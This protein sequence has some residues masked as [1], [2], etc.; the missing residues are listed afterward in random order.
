[1]R[2]GRLATL[3]T[4]VLG[5]GTPLVSRFLNPHRTQIF[6]LNHH[7]VSKDGG[8]DRHERGRIVPRPRRLHEGLQVA[9]R[10]ESKRYVVRRSV[11]NPPNPV[12][13]LSL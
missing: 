10:Q 8:L 11:T 9:L 7:R 4:H 6:R 12:G 5:V 13:L 3:G 1:M 2:S